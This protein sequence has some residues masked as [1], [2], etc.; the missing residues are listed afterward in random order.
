MSFF[1]KWLRVCKSAW[2][3]GFAII[4]NEFLCAIAFMPSN[5]II[6]HLMPFYT[7]SAVSLNIGIECQYWHVSKSLPVKIQKSAIKKEAAHIFI[8]RTIRNQ[9]YRCV[10]VMGNR[11]LFTVEHYMESGIRQLKPTHDLP[12]RKHKSTCRPSQTTAGIDQ[13][14]Q[15]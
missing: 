15:N 2:F 8:G 1:E 7:L 14:T 5:G 11:S 13:T 9:Q 6:S 10:D 4:F 12:L 3:C